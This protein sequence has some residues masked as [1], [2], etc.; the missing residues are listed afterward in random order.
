[1]A[2][3]T[4]ELIDGTQ[5]SGSAPLVLIGPNGSGKSRMAE[6]LKLQRHYQLVRARRVPQIHI[7]Q[8]STP[9]PGDLSSFSL[10]NILT[11]FLEEDSEES[12][13]FTQRCRVDPTTRGAPPTTR[14]SQLIELFGTIFPGRRLDLS[15]QRPSVAW[16][17]A[18]R[19]TAEYA[20]DSM[21]DG[22]KAGV[23][24]IARLIRAEPGVVIVDEPEVHLHSLLAR[25]FWTRVQSFRSDCRFI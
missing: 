5:V 10:P 8:F 18:A 14:V 23:D 3:H 15:S 17:A 1:M 11:E 2:E 9:R 22:E 7:E 19:T 25:E 21:S 6:P 4:I 13:R 20:A 16:T 12:R 24:L